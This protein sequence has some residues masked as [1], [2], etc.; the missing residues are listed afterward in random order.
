MTGHYYKLLFHPT[1]YSHLLP[2]NDDT[3][4]LNHKIII[5][6]QVLMKHFGDL[7]LFLLFCDIFG[8]FALFIPFYN[9]QILPNNQ[10]ASFDI[11]MMRLLRGA[12]KRY[13]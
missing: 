12:V 7:A 1:Q 4:S 3:T 6:K 13:R 5:G 11:A 8:G 2:F 10:Q 9:F